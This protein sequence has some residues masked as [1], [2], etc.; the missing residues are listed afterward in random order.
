MPI[1][2]TK[3]KWRFFRAGGFEQVLLESGADLLALR[4]LD[5]KL[6]AALSCPADGI[7]FDSQTLALIDTDNDGRI[8]APELLAAIEWAGS[9]LRDPDSLV[10]GTGKVP[11]SAIADSAEG[12]RLLASARQ[13]L[14]N[15]GKK[16]AF[17]ITLD[18]TTDRVKIFA[19]TKLN[20]DGVVPPASADDEDVRKAI[21]EIIGI[22][23]GEKDRNGQDGVTHEKLN[24]FFAEA[25]AYTKWL[26]AAEDDAARVLPLG[27]ATAAA[28]AALRAVRPKIDD[29][30]TRVKL[31]AFDA[32]AA[33]PLS[34]TL[35]QRSQLR[36]SM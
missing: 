19:E 26:Q 27:E 14:K 24:D 2:K 5:Q 30:F 31:A 34:A 9:I 29:Y 25:G 10:K 33:A 8:R 28:A 21:E 17:E 20:G 3:H 32:R 1:D 12:K 4:E 15:L 6:W 22:T 35:T 23:G 36:P 13:I 18:D 11:L 7:E 16:D